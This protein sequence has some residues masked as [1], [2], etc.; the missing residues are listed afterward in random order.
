MQHGLN[1]PK[2]TVTS[3]VFAEGPRWVI[4][5]LCSANHRF[6]RFAHPNAKI[7]KHPRHVVHRD[8]EVYVDTQ[9]GK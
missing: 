1:M 5:P 6:E 7:K 2:Q 3:D 9:T 8:L 4:L